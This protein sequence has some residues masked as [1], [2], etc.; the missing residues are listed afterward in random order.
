MEQLADYL[1]T[2]PEALQRHLDEKSVPVLLP[3]WILHLKNNQS[4]LYHWPGYHSRV[5]HRSQG[6]I[7]PLLTPSKNV[8]HANRNVFLAEQLQRLSKAYENAALY[9]EEQ[10][11]A[12]NFHK[13]AG[14]L[15]CLDFEVTRD[16]FSKALPRLKEI[17]GFGNSVR[18]V[19]EDI[20]MNGHCRRIEYLEQDPV[21]IAVSALSK[22]HGIGRVQ[23]RG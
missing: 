11:K 18:A 19:V 9:E 15:Q 4:F 23:V 8:R 22:V 14:R 2:R 3:Q 5:I 16:T 20:V 10:W 12:L 1:D 6:Q 21:R 17:P 13:L 7:V